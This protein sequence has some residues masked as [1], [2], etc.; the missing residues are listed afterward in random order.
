MKIM[1]ENITNYNYTANEILLTKNIL[2]N[3]II[4]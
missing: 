4:K 3:F 1:K 2:I